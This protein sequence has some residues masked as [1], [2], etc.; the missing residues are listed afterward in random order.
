M[1]RTLCLCLAIPALFACRSL[2]LEDRTQCPSFL[3]F[4]IAN[5]STCAVYEKGHVSAFSYPD[6]N[7]LASD[8]TRLSR[9]VSRDF[10]LKVHKCEAV[11]GYGVLGLGHAVR[12]GQSRITVAEGEDFVPLFRFDYLSPAREEKT[13]IPVELV[14]DHAR[15]HVRFVGF[16][17]FTGAEGIF[18]FYIE[19]RSNTAGIDA[20]SG[21]PVRGTYRCVPEEGFAGEFDFI[22]PRQG[23]HSLRMDLHAKPGVYVEDGLVRSFDLWQIFRDHCRI[24]WDEKNLPDLSLEIDYAEWTC[25]VKVMEWE[26]NNQLHY[27]L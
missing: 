15:V 11:R 21:I 7:S 13:L 2:I 23:D 27:E 16:D 19:V 5:A 10:Y 6:G 24:G 4:D 22:L 26:Q 9:I 18:P 3:F 1:K 12:E 25:S 14:K 8:T 17:A 20:L